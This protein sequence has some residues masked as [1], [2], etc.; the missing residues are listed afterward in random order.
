M[1]AEEATRGGLDLVVPEMRWC[2][3]NGAMIAALGT[4]RLDAGNTD[5]LTLV[6]SATTRT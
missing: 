1:L 3:D 2:Q 4:L 6:P 5:D